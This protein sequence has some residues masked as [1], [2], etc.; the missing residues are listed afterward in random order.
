MLITPTSAR[1]GSGEW[2]PGPLPDDERLMLHITD[3]TVAWLV[4]AASA[5]GISSSKSCNRGSSS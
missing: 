3:I 2:M 4:T 1:Y 5:R